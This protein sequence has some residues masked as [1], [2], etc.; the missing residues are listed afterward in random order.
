MVLKM[1]RDGAKNALKT[2]LKSKLLKNSKNIWFLGVFW[3]K[4]YNHQKYVKNTPKAAVSPLKE[5]HHLEKWSTDFFGRKGLIST[6]GNHPTF[7]LV[8]F[9]DWSFSALSGGIIGFSLRQKLS[10][11]HST[12]ETYFFAQ[13]IILLIKLIQLKTYPN[14]LFVFFSSNIKIKS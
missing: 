13:N 3:L 5:P 6:L 8:T 14:M 10:K 11:I 7:F 2:S 1:T 4:K 9:M 12:Y